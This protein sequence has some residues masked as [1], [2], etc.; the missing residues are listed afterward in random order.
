M[1]NI[2]AYFILLMIFI[3]CNNQAKE[4][5]QNEEAE[6]VAEVVAEKPTWKI[7]GTEPFWNIHIHGDT[8]LYTRLNENI[9]SIYFV[10]HHYS[11]RDSIVEF[12]LMYQEKEAGL[13]LRKSS[14][15]CSDGMSDNQYA[16]S[17][18]FIYG[19]ETLK[20]CATRQ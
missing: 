9:D 14:T 17:A 10:N 3:S 5:V 18:T 12:H 8:V 6:P 2:F 1:K 16:Y 15:P 11:D 7:L 20:G 13:T 19:K 4:E